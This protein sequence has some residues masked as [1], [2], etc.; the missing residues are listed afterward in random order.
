MGSSIQAEDAPCMD[1][2]FGLTGTGNRGWLDV[3][4]GRVRSEARKCLGEFLA[5][6][7]EFAFEMPGQWGSA[8]FRKN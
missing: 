8:V 1:G 3:M 7:P 4:K 2:R 5:D 6:K